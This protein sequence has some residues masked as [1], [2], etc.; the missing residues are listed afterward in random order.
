GGSSVAENQTYINGLNVTDIYRRQGSSTAP[1]GFFDQF[2]VKTGGYSVEFGRSTGGVIN[3]SVRS[4]G[5]EFHGGMQLTFEPEGLSSNAKDRIYEHD[6]P[7]QFPTTYVRGS[8]D[9]ADFTKMNG[10]FSGPL[11]KD[12]LFFFAMYEARQSDS[13]NTNNTGSTWSTSTADNGFWGGRLDWNITDNHQLSLVAFSDEGDSVTKR[14]SYD[15]DTAVIGDYSGETLSDYG[16]QNGTLTYTGH[17]GDNFVAKV[18]YGENNRTAFSRSPLDEFCS[19]VSLDGSYAG[20]GALLGEV[21]GCHPTGSS[22]NTQDDTR[23]IGRVDFEWTL[24]DHLLRFGFDEER[25]TT[26]QTIFYPGPGG[27]ALQAQTRA[28]GS[29][30][31]DTSGVILTETTDVIRARRRASGGAF[32]TVN[33]AFYIEDNWNFTNNLLLTLGVRVD[34]FTNK[35]ADGEAF[36]DIDNLIAPRVGFS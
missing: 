29:E 28:A 32:E 21:I 19:P 26:D 7:T 3:A 34:N 30:I 11:L 25:L 18:M 16:G 13:G 1:F 2:E 35:T 8:R 6:N 24:G 33:N 12:R 20:A 27:V 23:E 10:W 15:W 14:Y 9:R 31:W 36:I 5:N 22:I 4:G 17:F